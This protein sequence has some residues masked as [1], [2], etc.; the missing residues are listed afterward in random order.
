[1]ENKIVVVLLQYFEKK[2]EL[3]ENIFNKIRSN[4]KFEFYTIIPEKITDKD[5]IQKLK[6]IKPKIVISPL[7]ANKELKFI[8]EI[9]DSIEYIHLTGSGVEKL[10]EIFPLLKKKKIK[11]INI[12]G[13]FSLPLAEWCILASLYFAKKTPYFLKKSKNKEWVE[14]IQLDTLEEK[15]GLI[16]GL[17][18]IGSLLAKKLHYGFSLKLTVVKKNINILKKDLN[19]IKDIITLDQL[20]NRISEFDFI[21]L[22]LPNLG[23]GKL[24]N[25]ELI[26]KMKK[27]VI[28]INV[29]RGDIIDE[30]GL[31]K[32]IKN[33]IIK[34][35]A[36]D[37][38]ENEP[39][40]KNSLFY[41]DE[42]INEKI[43]NSCHKALVF[44][45]C[46]EE[47]FKIV[48]R[49]LNNFLNKK[50]MDFE[51]CLENGY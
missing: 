24:I 45:Y 25:F 10:K 9:C 11:L 49:N 50:M 42:E 38:W 26:K 13:A 20:E 3:I 14:K 31:F 29:G 48:N 43:L 51:V 35:A 7:K 15:K 17:G 40:D 33:G 16:L 21:Y 39:L 23:L 32:G 27:G 22:C 28:L 6:N 34:G 2:N 5:Y 18:S 4:T 12:K 1:M 41:N 19:F 47:I 8:I 37:V 36:L 46:V 30:D 44:D